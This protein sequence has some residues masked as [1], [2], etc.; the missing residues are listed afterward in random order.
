MDDKQIEL[1][2]VL[3]CVIAIALIAAIV[4]AV[5]WVANDTE[6]AFAAACQGKAVFNGRFW[7]CL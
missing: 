1:G 6:N 5:A 4:V 7:V 3:A 2:L